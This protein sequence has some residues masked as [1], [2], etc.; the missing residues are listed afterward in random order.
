MMKPWIENISY[1]DVEKGFHYDPGPNAMMIQI[2]D[3]GMFFPTPKYSFKKISQYYFLDVEEN[4]IPGAI[5]DAAIQDSDVIGIGKDLQY[6]LANDMNVI[7]SCVMGVCR[8]G[9]VAEVGVMLGFQDTEKYRIPNTMV[10]RKLME[11][12]GMTYTE[13][14]TPKGAWALD[15][16]GIRHYY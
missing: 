4:D 5:F 10:K 11:Y 2:V 14:Q 9:A 1:S 8:S 3:P 7:V 13:S 6:A 16:N 12:F 15:E